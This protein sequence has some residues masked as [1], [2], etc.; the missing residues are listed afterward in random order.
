MAITKPQTLMGALGQMAATLTHSVTPDRLAKI[1][2]SVP[3]VLILS[4]AEDTL[5]P[6]T[7]GENLK[8][9]MP[10]AEYQCW[11]KTGAWCM[12]PIQ[13]AVQPAAGKGVRARK[14]GSCPAC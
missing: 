6:H 5:I 8:R 2:A 9:H 13:G 4:A 7:E 12:R 14:G 11:E 1:S 3:K 10:E